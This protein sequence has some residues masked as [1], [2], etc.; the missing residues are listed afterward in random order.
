ML[1][2]DGISTLL[3]LFLE[4]FAISKPAK[5]EMAPATWSQSSRFED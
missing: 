2:L 1:V 5:K 4:A 3:L